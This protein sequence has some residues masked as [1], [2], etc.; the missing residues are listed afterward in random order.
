MR[1]IGHLEGHFIKTRCVVCGCGFDL[2][3]HDE[4]LCSEGEAVSYDLYTDERQHLGCVCYDCIQL[5]AEA[6]NVQMGTA[7]AITREWIAHLEIS[8]G[9]SIVP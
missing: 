9:K 7:E 3:C 4:A 2:G 8:T 5:P 6:I 1:L